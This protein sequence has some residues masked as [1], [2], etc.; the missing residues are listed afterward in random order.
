MQAMRYIKKLQSVVINDFLG[1]NPNPRSSWKINIGLLLICLLCIPLNIN[2]R[3]NTLSLAASTNL[4][5]LERAVMTNYE[6]AKRL[7]ILGENTNTMN[8][9]NHQQTQ[10]KDARLKTKA[11][12]VTVLQ[13]DLVT[14]SKN[15]ETL[16]P[17][18]RDILN[19]F[20]MRNQ[21]RLHDE[22][23]H[24]NAT[25]TLFNTYQTGILTSFIADKK[26]L[27]P[28]PSV[29]NLIKAGKTNDT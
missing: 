22:I 26:G 3:L 2:N 25:V 16:P 8:R 20:L 18:K 11:H 27:Q 1:I 9:I 15:I 13:D 29:P 23:Q 24:F 14:L 6:F 4:S 10:F 21:H 17:N 5:Y 12:F 7:A 19:E 28:L